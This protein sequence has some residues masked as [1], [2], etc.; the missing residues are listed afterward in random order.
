MKSEDQLAQNWFTF[1]FFNSFVFIDFA[2]VLFPLCLLCT[3]IFLAKKIVL[4]N[5]YGV[6]QLLRLHLGGGMFIKT[7]TYTSS[8]RWG[9]FHC[10]RL[11]I[12]VFN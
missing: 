10:K 11:H 3:Y 7:R 8:E 9:S 5:L 4:I 2:L 6:I 12:T 1:N